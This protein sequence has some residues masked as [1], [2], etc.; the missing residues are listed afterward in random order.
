MGWRPLREQPSINVEQSRKLQEQTE[1]NI[2]DQFLSTDYYENLNDPKDLETFDQYHHIFSKGFQENYDFTQ[3]LTSSVMAINDQLEPDTLP[4][5]ISPG[6]SL[7]INPRLDSK[8]QTQLI[9]ILQKQSGE[10]TW[11][12]K[13]MHGIHPNTCIHHIYT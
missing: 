13:D 12:Y 7:Y 9:Q 1:E 10:F 11:E 2:L 5:E 8:Q 4:V 6:K 3:P